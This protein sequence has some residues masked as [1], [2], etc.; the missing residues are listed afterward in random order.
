MSDAK[1]QSNVRVVTPPVITDT[2]ILA[3]LVQLSD[4]SGKVQTYVV[5][6][7]WTPG[8]VTIYSLMVA[9]ESAHEQ[10]LAKMGYTEEQIAEI[11]ETSTP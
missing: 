9:P 2:G 3:R 6:H 4:G 10:N 8:G 7:G 11:L 1:G 5:P